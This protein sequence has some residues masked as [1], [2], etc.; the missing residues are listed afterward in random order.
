MATDASECPGPAA[1]PGDDFDAQLEREWLI[2]NGRGGYASGTVLGLPTRRY[3][4]LLV[5]AARPPLERWLLLS[6]VLERVEAR[7]AALVAR[8]DAL[9]GEARLLIDAPEMTEATSTSVLEITAQLR[10][11]DRDDPRPDAPI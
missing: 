3:H 2:T 11:I 1:R 10:R 9:V 7:R 6:A 5:A 8:Q 4:G